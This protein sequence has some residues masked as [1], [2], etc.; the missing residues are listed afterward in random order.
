MNYQ[1]S[2][3]ICRVPKPDLKKG[4]VVECVTCGEYGSSSSGRPHEEL[5]LLGR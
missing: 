3:C 1:G 4:V 5:S 2:T